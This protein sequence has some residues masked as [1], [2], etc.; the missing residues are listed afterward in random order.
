MVRSLAA[1]PGRKASLDQNRTGR[2]RWHKASRREPSRRS[3]AP[4]GGTAPRSGPS[5]DTGRLP[6]FWPSPSMPTFWG[7]VQHASS[8]IANARPALCCSSSASS[9]SRV[10]VLLSME[11][12]HQFTPPTDRLNVPTAVNR[13]TATSQL[14]QLNRPPFASPPAMRSASS[15]QQRS[16][17]D[18]FAER[19]L[20][21]DLR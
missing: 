10:S 9:R 5:R 12:A 20:R 17:A 1:W 19:I 21:V 7:A 4:S 18:V 14:D 15:G 3:S 2:S 6:E 8:S 11:W 13:Q 16:P